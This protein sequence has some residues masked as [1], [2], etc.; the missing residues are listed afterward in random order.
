MTK[1]ELPLEEDK[2]EIDRCPFCWGSADYCYCAETN[3]NEVDN[4]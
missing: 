4:D 2:E 1:P 3:G